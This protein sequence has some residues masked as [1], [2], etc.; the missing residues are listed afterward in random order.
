[1]YKFDQIKKN[2]NHGNQIQTIC[3]HIPYFVIYEQSLYTVVVDFYFG[4]VNE[5]V[6]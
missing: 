4:L 5:N 6:Q 2:R 3:E 1:M